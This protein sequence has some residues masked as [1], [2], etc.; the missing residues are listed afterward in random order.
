MRRYLQ[1]KGRWWVHAQSQALDPDPVPDPDTPTA[2]ETLQEAH[3]YV[4]REYMAQAL[5][6]R[7]RFRGVE[8]RI[9][10]QKMGL[11]AQ[12]IGDTFQVLVGA[13]SDCF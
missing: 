13:P 4:V 7:E 6:P 12:T 2:Q 11:D 10:S 3:R 5:R 9:C 8:R 1:G